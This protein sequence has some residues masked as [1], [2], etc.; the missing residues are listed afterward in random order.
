MPDTI[1]DLVEDV[2]DET[3]ETIQAVKS[4]KKGVFNV[5][6]QTRK[7]FQIRTLLKSG[8]DIFEQYFSI[9]PLINPFYLLFAVLSLI[10]LSILLIAGSILAIISVL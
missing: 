6:G 2:S 7:L 9:G 4:G 1:N 5:I 10:C 3:S 8:S